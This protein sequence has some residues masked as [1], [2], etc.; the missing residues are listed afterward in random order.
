MAH[1]H[2]L[3]TVGYYATALSYCKQSWR[4]NI[5]TVQGMPSPV[6][7]NN[8]TINTLTLNGPE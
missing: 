4:G 5:V 2:K 7:N 6:K 1:S 8:I 3:D